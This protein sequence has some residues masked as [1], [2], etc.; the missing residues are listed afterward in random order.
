MQAAL[1]TP[2]GGT[3]YACRRHSIWLQPALHTVA[4]CAPY[5]CRLDRAVGSFLA[6][7]LG[8]SGA[9]VTVALETH[10]DLVEIASPEVEIASPEAES[11]SSE[12]GIASPDVESESADVENASP[13]AEIGAPGGGREIGET[14]CGDEGGEGSGAGGEGGEGGEG[15]GAGGEVGGEA[16]E[17]GEAVEAGEGGEMGEAGEVGEVGVGAGQFAERF[18]VV[19]DP[20]DGVNS[21]DAGVSIG[22]TIGTCVYTSCLG[23]G[24]AP[25]HAACLRLGTSSSSASPSLPPLAPVYTACFSLALARH[26]LRHNP[27]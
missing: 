24:S 12:A 27:S 19:L 17:V 10:E 1:P 4:G 22:A 25:V 18:A 9:C 11:E 7:T 8:Q 21:A 14:P 16:G 5:G 3:P 26:H 20:L 6:E 13:E 23:L 15:S 2:A